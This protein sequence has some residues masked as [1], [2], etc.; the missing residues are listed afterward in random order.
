[1]GWFTTGCVAGAVIG[2]TVYKVIEY[3][4]VEFWND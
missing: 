2:I 3:V 4:V 1:M